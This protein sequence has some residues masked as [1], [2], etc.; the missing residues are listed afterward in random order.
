MIT[1]RCSMLPER[2]IKPSFDKNGPREVGQHCVFSPGLS[3]SLILQICNQNV[4]LCRPRQFSRSAPVAPPQRPPSRLQP[5]MSS[6]GMP[7]R[8]S[9]S[10]HKKRDREAAAAKAEADEAA[11][12]EA[13]A[14]AQEG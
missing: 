1:D 14:D 10:Q 3:I 13:E 11:R 8:A 9:K 7:T 5:T 2:S 12:V 4:H 6:P